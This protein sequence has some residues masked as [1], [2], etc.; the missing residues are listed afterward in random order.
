MKLFSASLAYL[1]YPY[2]FINC[3]DGIQIINGHYIHKES[4]DVTSNTCTRAGVSTGLISCFRC[5][6]CGL[7]RCVCCFVDN[8]FKH[9]KANIYWN[10]CLFRQ[11]LQLSID[12]PTRKMMKLPP[13]APAN[14]NHNNNRTLMWNSNGRQ[15]LGMC[16]N[17]LYPNKRNPLDFSEFQH[18]ILLQNCRRHGTI[19]CTVVSFWYIL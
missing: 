12:F 14:G 6:P 15:M 9:T 4:C 17:V 3:R 5:W 7:F 19:I 1:L 8:E 2:V 18:H 13:T 10:R 11:C 16:L